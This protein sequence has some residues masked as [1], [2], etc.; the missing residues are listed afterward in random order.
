[1]IDDNEVKEERKNDE[2]EISNLKK[3]IINAIEFNWIF[4]GDTAK[5]FII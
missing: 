3:V 1:M 4:K 2:S 5:E